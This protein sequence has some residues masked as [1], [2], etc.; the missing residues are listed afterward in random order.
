MLVIQSPFVR[1]YTRSGGV[2]VRGRG[3]DI[4]SGGGAYTPGRYTR[5]GGGNIRILRNV[6][7]TLFKMIEISHLCNLKC[8]DL[9]VSNEK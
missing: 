6:V 7:N 3:G 4:F 9:N 8:R 1:A 5:E 2:Y